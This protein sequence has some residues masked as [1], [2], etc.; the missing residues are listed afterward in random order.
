MC[1]LLFWTRLVRL[2]ESA[3]IENSNI[4]VFLTVED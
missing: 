2:T 3:R 1:L 4:V